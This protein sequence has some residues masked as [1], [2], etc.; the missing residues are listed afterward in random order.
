MTHST[1]AVFRNDAYLREAEAA[2]VAINDRGGIILDRTI[3]YATSGGQPGD[4]GSFRREMAAR[5]SRSPGP[6]P[7]RPRMRSSTCLR[8]ARKFRRWASR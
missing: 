4:T 3:F 5:R 7:A 1:E 6:L 8:P 2:V